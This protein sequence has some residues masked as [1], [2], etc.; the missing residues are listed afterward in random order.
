MMEVL[1]MQGSL[2]IQCKASDGSSY[3]FSLS[4]FKKLAT[5]GILKVNYD[6][7]IM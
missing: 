5:D 7:D 2:F 1:T 4:H 3:Y 6:Q